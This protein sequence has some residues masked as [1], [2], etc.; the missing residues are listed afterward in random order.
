[1][2]NGLTSPPQSPSPYRAR[3]RYDGLCKESEEDK[4]QQ[5]T[6]PPQSP[7]PYRARGKREGLRSRFGLRWVLVMLCC[8][9]LLGAAC[10]PAVCGDGALDNN[11]AC[12]D[13]NNTDNDGCNADCSLSAVVQ[14]AVGDAHTC[15]Q[16][17]TGA[18][19]CWGLGVPACLA[20]AT[21]THRR[22]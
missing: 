9:V 10:K 13:A 18:V 22:R 21:K 17:N 11:E 19:R 6:S 7:S 5:E 8:G 2:R 16:L 20:T 12:D 3:G 14:V 15:A 1:M 4:A